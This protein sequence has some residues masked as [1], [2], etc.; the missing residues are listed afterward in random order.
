MCLYKSRFNIKKKDDSQKVR[1]SVYYIRLYGIVRSC[2]QHTIFGN[3]IHFTGFILVLWAWLWNNENIPLCRLLEIMRGKSSALHIQD[4]R[5]LAFLMEESKRFV[6]EAGACHNTKIWN[7]WKWMESMCYTYILKCS[8]GT[9]YTGWTN[10]SG[11][12]S[13]SP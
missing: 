5:W 9:Y 6:S 3:R 8:D 2:T 4:V 12:A 13:Q 1:E 10:E 11:Q 7:S